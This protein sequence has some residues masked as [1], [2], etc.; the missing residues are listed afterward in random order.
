MDEEEFMANF[1]KNFDTLFSRIVA[2]TEEF[3]AECDE[4]EDEDCDCLR[5]KFDKMLQE[6]SVDV[7]KEHSCLH[8]FE[9]AVAAT[10]ALLI[11]LQG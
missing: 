11:K 8:E 4:D 3:Y 7:I 5:C 10:A 9:N 1:Y 6:T 2:T